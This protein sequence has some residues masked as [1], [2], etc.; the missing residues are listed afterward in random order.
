LTTSS[1]P[2]PLRVRPPRGALRACRPVR[3]PTAGSPPL[4]PRSLVPSPRR[5]ADRVWGRRRTASL[6][7][8]RKLASP[9]IW[10]VA[11]RS[12]GWCRWWFVR[13]SGLQAVG[14]ED[15]RGPQ[16][17]GVDRISL[18]QHAAGRRRARPR[19]A[20]GEV[21]RTGNR[22]RRREAATVH[23][24][25]RESAAR[26]RGWAP[27]GGWGGSAGAGGLGARDRAARR[28]APCPQRCRGPASPG[29]RGRAAR[30]GLAPLAASRLALA[31]AGR[32]PRRVL[33]PVA[34]VSVGPCALGLVR[35]VLRA[36]G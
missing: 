36:V 16:S 35:L 13:S 24:P 4:G 26:C 5:S 3:G 34:L 33:E 2:P 1:A 25:K 12:N 31:A 7:R 9:L 28:A 14:N 23:L 29:R 21:G 27:R 19:R 22:R 17:E 8:W 11:N 32:P 15:S 10:P 30:E 6:C 18:A 20:V